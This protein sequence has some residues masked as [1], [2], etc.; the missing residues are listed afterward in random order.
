MV[1]GRAFENTQAISKHIM[2]PLKERPALSG[3]LKT[4]TLLKSGMG[5]I[6]HLY[7]SKVG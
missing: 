4:Q 5:V 7:N 2:E 6:P 3:L 1:I